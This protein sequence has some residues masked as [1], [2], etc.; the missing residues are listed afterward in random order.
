M[1]GDYAP[2]W[3]ATTAGGEVFGPDSAPGQVLLLGMLSACSAP[4]IRDFLDALTIHWPSLERLGCAVRCFVRDAEMARTPCPFPV[5][6]DCGGTIARAFSLPLAERA[7]GNPARISVVDIDGRLLA[8]APLEVSAAGAKAMVSLAQEY[9]AVPAM[10]PGLPVL[11]LRGALSRKVCGALI[12][13]YKAGRPSAGRVVRQRGSEAILSVVPGFK[14]RED[15]ILQGSLRADI[16]EQLYWRVLPAV[17]RTFQ[18][19]IT[20]FEYLQVGRYGADARGRFAPHRDDDIPG[21]AHRR[22]AMSVNLNDEYQGGEL[23][24][25]ESGARLRPGIGEAVVF[26]CSL[27]HEATLVTVG[28]RF[29]LVGMFWGERQI[30]Q[31]RRSLAVR[32]VRAA[33]PHHLS[34]LGLLDESAALLREIAGDVTALSRVLDATGNDIDERLGDIH[35]ELRGLRH[36][37]RV[38]CGPDGGTQFGGNRTT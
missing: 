19:M 13:A 11:S 33:D 12:D 28:E 6:I 35:H 5:L 17:R 3:S 20:R 21:N 22:F 30:G 14:T 23:R 10:A 29:V 7:T 25:L 24:F 16:S 27:L 9:A 2:V 32:G 34:R 37:L 18:F 26:S 38:L 36:S 8:S 4:I 1:A 31:Y 15:L